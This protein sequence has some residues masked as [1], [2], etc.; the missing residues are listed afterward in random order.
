[1]YYSIQREICYITLV[2]YIIIATL[3][4]YG[5]KLVRILW[6]NR[7]TTSYQ[8]SDENKMEMKLSATSLY[9]KEN[10]SETISEAFND[11]GANEKNAEFV[12]QTIVKGVMKNV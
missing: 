7:Q 3:K 5:K 11:V 4:I 10:S 2:I 8:R 1:M 9:G 6:K 12:N